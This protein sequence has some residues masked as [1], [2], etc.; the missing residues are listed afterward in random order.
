MEAGN[1]KQLAD[2]V[3]AERWASTQIFEHR[4]VGLVFNCFLVAR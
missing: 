2:L 4:P 3:P 1:R